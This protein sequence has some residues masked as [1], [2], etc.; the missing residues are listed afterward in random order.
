[1]YSF[2]SRMSGIATTVNTK[3]EAVNSWVAEKD[4]VTFSN[5]TL[6]PG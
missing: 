1:M 3:K 5:V 4:V 6:W 2:V